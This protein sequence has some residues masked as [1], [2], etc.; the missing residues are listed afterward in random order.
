MP[1]RLH[2]RVARRTAPPIALVAHHLQCRQIGLEALEKRSRPV[3]GAVVT[4]NDLVSG[5]LGVFVVVPREDAPFTHHAEPGTEIPFH[6][7]IGM[8][9]VDGDEVE[10]AIDL[11]DRTVRRLP[12]VT[13]AAAKTGQPIERTLVEGVERGLGEVHRVVVTG[14]VAIG[15]DP[16]EQLHPGAIQDRLAVPSEGDA[17]FR[18]AFQSE[19]IH[20]GR[21]MD[22]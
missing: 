10:E 12:E 14:L 8:V 9:G 4:D 19:P 3:G 13:V 7:F 18:S 15:V 2:G 17:D 22:V 16:V 21:Q 1:S 6:P 5:E 11:R 20:Q